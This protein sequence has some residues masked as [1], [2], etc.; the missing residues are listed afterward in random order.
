MNADYDRLYYGGMNFHEQIYVFDGHI[1]T[2]HDFSE[3][4]QRAIDY[5][6]RQ[7]LPLNDSSDPRVKGK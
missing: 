7:V 4:A 3:S 6:N 2:M 5:F 1:W